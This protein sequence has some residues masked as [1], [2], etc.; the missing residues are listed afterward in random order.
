MT[1]DLR[2]HRPSTL[3]HSEDLTHRAEAALGPIT[4][5]WIIAKEPAVASPGELLHALAAHDIAEL[6]SIRADLAAAVDEFV[7]KA[8]LPWSSSVDDPVVVLVRSI[9]R[10]SKVTPH[11]TSVAAARSIERLTPDL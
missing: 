8:G 7:I 6:V 2:T 5:D 10:L 1:T 3:V 4:T 9:I 11:T